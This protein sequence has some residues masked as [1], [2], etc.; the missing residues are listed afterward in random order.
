MTCRTLKVGDAVKPR[1]LLCALHKDFG[2]V[3]TW[4]FTL[5]KEFLKRGFEVFIAGPEDEPEG[6]FDFGLFSNIQYTKKF[7]KICKKSFNICHGIVEE[8]KPDPSL[9]I[10]YTSE[11][12]AKAWGFSGFLINQPIDVDFWHCK[13]LSPKERLLL[14]SYR[15]P[16]DFSDKISSYCEAIGFGF[17]HLKEYDAEQAKKEISKSTLVL[18]SGRAFLE[19]ASC[20]VPVMICDHRSTYQMP[21]ICTDWESS[22]FNNYSG[23]GK[24]SQQVNLENF[25]RGFRDCFDRGSVRERVI[26]S[27]SAEQ[28]CEQFSKLFEVHSC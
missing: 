12:N 25:R 17:R 27:H 1:L 19:A 9:P 21:F 16:E 8:E 10:V 14:L 26:A 6:D 18:A 3:S 2:G 7:L 23:R 4:M 13:E 22:L 5:E 28:V 20:G 24:N 15:A 11:S